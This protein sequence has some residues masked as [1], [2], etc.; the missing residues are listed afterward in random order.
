MSPAARGGLF[1][2]WVALV[3]YAAL[4][5]PEAR[6]DQTAWI[7]RLLTGDWAGEDPWVVVVF[8]LL[9]VWPFAMAALLAPMLRRAPVPLWPFALSSFAIGAFGLLPG[10]A[11]G[12]ETQPMARWQRWL[13]HP[14]LRVSLA[15]VVLVLVAWGVAAGQPAVFLDAFATEQLVHV[16]TFDFAAL[17]ITSIVVAREQGRAWGWAFVPILGALGVAGAAES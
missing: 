7:W 16:M 2:L 14:V 8:N 4:F 10:L 1:A 3:G 15:A 9:G 5:A 13:F 6:P 11:L 17:W 12:G